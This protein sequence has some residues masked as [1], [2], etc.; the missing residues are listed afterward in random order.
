MLFTNFG[1]FF[2][3]EKVSTEK[4]KSRSGTVAATGVYGTILYY[5][6]QI[7]TILIVAQNDI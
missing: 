4:S 5:N 2:R 3:Q 7:E 1:V 6:F